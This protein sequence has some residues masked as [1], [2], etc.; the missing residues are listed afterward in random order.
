MRR[1]LDWAFRDRETGRITVAQWPNAPL[2]LFAAGSLAA[3]LMGSDDGAGRV[4]RLAATACLVV[5]SVDEIV[6]GVNPWRRILGAG[7]LGGVILL[8]AG[9]A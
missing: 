9:P 8:A 6:R 7:V 4:L 1:A 5:W 2:W 3:H